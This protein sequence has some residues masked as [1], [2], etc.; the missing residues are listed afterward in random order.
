M[1]NETIH[2]YSIPLLL[3]MIIKMSQEM[4][5]VVFESWKTVAIACETSWLVVAERYIGM[6]KGHHLQEDFRQNIYIVFE[7]TPLR[8]GLD[9][10]CRKKMQL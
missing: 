2:K 3:V 8:F 5:N 6:Q 10:I 9:P 4:T 7:W 1:Y